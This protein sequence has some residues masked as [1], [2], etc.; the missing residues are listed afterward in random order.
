MER[1]HVQR[2]DSGLAA[3]HGLFDA[4]GDGFM[5]RPR[6]PEA[7]DEPRSSGARYEDRMARLM[8]LLNR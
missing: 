8:R 2:Q 4:E 1:T 5:A 3:A 6:E 7:F